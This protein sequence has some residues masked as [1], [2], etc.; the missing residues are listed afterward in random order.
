MFGTSKILKEQLVK[1]QLLIQQQ[2]SILNALNRSMAVIEFDLQGH[3]LTANENFLSALGYRLDEIV[4]KHHRLFVDNS[5]AQSAEYKAFWQRLA[6]GEFFGGR[7]K[8]LTKSGR[9]IW[10]EATYNPVFNEHNQLIKVI[11]FASDITA[12]VE[13]E[14][15]AQ[16]QIE[17]INRAMATIEFDLQGIILTAN[18]NFLATVGYSLDEVVGK[19]H[20]MFAEPSYAQSADYQAFWQRL[21]AGEFFT[22]TYKR[23]GKGGKEVWIEASYNPI[24]GADG[25]PYKIVK[26]A[27]DVG[28]SPNMKLLQS[29]VEKAVELINATASG[30]LTAKL[31]LDENYQN[32]IFCP[33]IE[34]LREALEKMSA[35]LHQSIDNTLHVVSAFS[36]LSADVSHNT[37]DLTNRMQSQAAA[38]EESSATLHEITQTVSAN[39]ETSQQVVKLAHNMQTQAIDAAKVMTLTIAAMQ[40]ISTS[41][42]KIADI[43]TLIDGIAFQTNLLALNAAVEAAR[44]GEHGR[45]FAVVAGEVRALAQ[46]SSDAA[47]EIRELISD[48]VTRIEQGTTLADKSGK[49]LGEINQS[50]SGVTSMIESIAQ[51]SQEQ[52]KAVNAIHQA[53][54]EIDRITQENTH[55]VQNTSSTAEHLSSEA[56]ALSQNLTFFTTR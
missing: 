3:I 22:G 52:T 15:N 48:S 38:L 18:H 51:A 50:V 34:R 13:A 17:A 49:A 23:L 10:I 55:L 24:L 35:T 36:K 14:L 41:S 9:V 2:Q 7:Y 5:Y 29:V 16:G 39:T 53:I 20:R 45:G 44:A 28:Q 40:E 21:A 42:S 31:S 32:T 6:K 46:K 25:K 8:R 43:L 47:K 12:R 4:G 27:T 19:H 56:D 37:T 11:K 33:L 26:F 1:Q 30:N 54:I